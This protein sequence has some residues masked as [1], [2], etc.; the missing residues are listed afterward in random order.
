VRSRR[1]AQIADLTTTKAYRERHP[2]AVEAVELGGIRSAMAVPM[3]KD[4]ELVGL[5]AIHRCDV[6]PFDEKQIALLTN[7]AAQAVIAIE[8]GRLLNDLRQR[9][10]DLTD[11]LEQQ[12]ATAEVLGVISQSKFELQPIL[13]SVVD[14]AARLCRALPATVSTPDYLERER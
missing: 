5:I 12:T 8:N 11:S 13:Q 4:D 14:T 1:A 7:F 3:L 10:S 9:T 2:R 6:L